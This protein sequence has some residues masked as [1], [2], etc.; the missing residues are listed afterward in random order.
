MRQRVKALSPLTLASVKAMD[1]ADNCH[2]TIVCMNYFI[3]QDR[4]STNTTDLNSATIAYLGPFSVF[5]IEDDGSE[6]EC[7]TPIGEPKPIQP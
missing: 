1:I 3:C 4:R 7:C 2:T 5:F 6:I